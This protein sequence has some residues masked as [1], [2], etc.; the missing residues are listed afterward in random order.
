MS[1]V[2]SVDAG[3]LRARGCG[4][5]VPAPGG[6]GAACDLEQRGPPLRGAQ[7]RTLRAVPADVSTV[8]R[9]ALHLG[10]TGSGEARRT[11]AVPACTDMREQ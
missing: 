6:T 10:D 5:S 1:K 11:A 8:T 2:S 7:A 3:L 4:A 9:C